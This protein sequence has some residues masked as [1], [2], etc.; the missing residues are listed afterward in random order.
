MAARQ[1]DGE[2]RRLLH[3]MIEAWNGGD[4]AAF[5]E[6]FTDGAEFVSWRGRRVTGRAAI[7]ARHRDLFAGPLRGARMD[8]DPAPY[9][10]TYLAPDV[11]LV[12]AVGVRSTPCPRR[13]PSPSPR[14]E[15]VAG[16][17][18]RSTT[19][20]WRRAPNADDVGKGGSSA[21]RPTSTASMYRTGGA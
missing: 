5:A 3:D 8:L 17:S 12:V 21:P 4:A 18:R 15:K 13:W 9:E 14:Y 1:G 19:R 10:V 16:G 20:W 7:E 11:A 6:C 2:V